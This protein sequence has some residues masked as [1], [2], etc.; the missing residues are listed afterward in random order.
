MALKTLSILLSIAASLQGATGSYLSPHFP[1]EVFSLSFL[2]TAALTR[3]VTC[4]DGVNMATDAA[5]CVLFAVRDDIQQNLFDG[6]ECGEDVH[7]SL[8]LTFHDAIGIGSSG[9]VFRLSVA[10]SLIIPAI[11]E[12]ELTAR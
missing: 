5:C 11:V 10:I 3:R 4:P 6:G 8:R 1:S 12:E 2:S 9:L 7:E